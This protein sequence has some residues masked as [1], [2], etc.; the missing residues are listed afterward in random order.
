MTR[1]SHLNEKDTLTDRE[2]EAAQ[3]KAS[4]KMRWNK[5]ENLYR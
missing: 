5:N 2:K 3:K 4:T 1:V